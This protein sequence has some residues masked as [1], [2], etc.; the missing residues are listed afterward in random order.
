MGSETI[1]ETNNRGPGVESI[2]TD[3]NYVQIVIKPFMQTSDWFNGKTW[4]GRRRIGEA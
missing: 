4:N 3:P 1:N 2:A